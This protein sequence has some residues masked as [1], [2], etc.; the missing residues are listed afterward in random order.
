MAFANLNV[1]ISSQF[2]LGETGGEDVYFDLD[3]GLKYSLPKNFDIK[4]VDKAQF[5]N[6]EKL[7]LLYLRW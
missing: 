2:L 6:V 5:T 7:T 1:T 3:E 4:H